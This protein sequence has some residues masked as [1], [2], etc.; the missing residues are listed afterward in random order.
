MRASEDTHQWAVRE[1][2]L[3]SDRV[4]RKGLSKKDTLKLKFGE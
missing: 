3:T 1:K 4:A 2:S